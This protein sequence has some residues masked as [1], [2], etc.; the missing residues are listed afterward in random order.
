MNTV[1]QAC[2]GKIKSNKEPTFEVW[3][4][5]C[6]GPALSSRTI[7]MCGH[8]Q[9][10]HDSRAQLG[11]GNAREAPLY[12]KKKKKKK[13]KGN[14]TLGFKFL[15]DIRREGIPHA[16][17]AQQSHDNRCGKQGY[18]SRPR[19]RSTSN[20][21]FYPR[22]KFSTHF[23]HLLQVPVSEVKPGDHQTGKEGGKNEESQVTD[24]SLP[25]IA[26]SSSHRSPVND[27][28]SARRE[29]SEGYARSSARTP[30]ATL[31][32]RGEIVES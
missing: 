12:P 8:A 7:Q 3:S 9:L 20:G 14:S 26:Q 11:K 17:Y 25:P 5:R 19:S 13:K 10:D 2:R 15:R 23:W 31:P 21:R 24:N 18:S 28:S 27:L 32:A 22:S 6:Q 1:E 30:R 16:N 4:R 29:G